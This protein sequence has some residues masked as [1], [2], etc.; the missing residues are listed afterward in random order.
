VGKSS[1]QNVYVEKISVCHAMIKN[2]GSVWLLFHIEAC[3]HTLI[4]FTKSDNFIMLHRMALETKLKVHYQ[5][6]VILLHMEILPELDPP[7]SHVHN[8]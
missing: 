4:L 1:S 2:L 8:G 6:P 5:L 7:C 3:Y